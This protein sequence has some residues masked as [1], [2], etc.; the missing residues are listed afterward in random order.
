MEA[1]K[2]PLSRHFLPD[3]RTIWR[4]HFYAGL[5]CI[6]FVL[7][8]AA[9]GSIYLFKPQIEAW[10]DRPYDNLLAPGASQAAPATQ[11]EAALAAVPG[12]NLH[13]YELARHAGSSPQI[14]VGKGEDEFR[15]YLHPGDARVLHVVNEDERLMKRIFRLHGE[16]MAGDR[17]SLL[18]ELAASWTIVMVLTGLVLWWPTQTERFAGVLYPRIGQSGRVF[19]RDLHSV[20]GLWVSGFALF[21]LVTG[22]PWAKSWGSY[23]KK[24]RGAVSSVAVKQDWTTGRS[25]EI[26]QR[27]ARNGGGDS[28]MADHPMHS[29]APPR[30]GRKNRGRAGAPAPG[31][32]AAIDRVIPA[33]LPLN[34]AYPVQISPPLKKGDPWTAKSDSQNRMLRDVYTIDG[35]SAAILTHDTFSD[36]PIVDRAVSIGISAHEGHLFGFP[37]QLISLFTATSLALLAVSSVALW[38]RRRP[39]GVLG[40][41]VALEKPTLSRALVAL[42]VLM[43]IYLPMLGISII[44]LWLIERLLLRRL[45]GVGTWLGL[46]A[47][48]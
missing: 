42:I 23:F 45:P 17:G 24:M 15:V 12:S 34:L 32:Y 31:A 41:P 16:L 46:R 40:A 18:V 22:L 35:D 9:T 38:W 8:L 43:A 2:P 26:A 28:D 4:W 1:T 48:A 30:F 10:A 21:L 27:V 7:W 44:L 20:T 13:F 33:V 11:V 19:W 5:F 37:N 3:R 6:P 25:S 47:T 29:A 39:E 36:R 14:I